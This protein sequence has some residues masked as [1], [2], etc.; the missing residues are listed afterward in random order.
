MLWRAEQE[1][2]FEYIPVAFLVTLHVF[3]KAPL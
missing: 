1:E 3:E 2:A